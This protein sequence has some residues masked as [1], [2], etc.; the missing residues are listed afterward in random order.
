M[1]KVF[2][3]PIK[4]KNLVKRCN[5]HASQ[6]VKSLKDK[7]TYDYIIVGAGSAGSVLAHRLSADPMNKVLLLE[8][9]QDDKYFP[10]HVP[11][12][13]L[14]CIA[15]PRTDWLFKTTK[16]STLN[17]R[18][19][20]YPRGKCLGGCSSINGML[21]VRGQSEDYDEWARL[22]DDENWSW[23]NMLPLYKSHEDYHGLNKND[24]SR[25]FNNNFEYMN[26]DE[27]Y[28]RKYHGV[29]GPWAVS[30]PR[31][32][33]PV[34]DI[35]R[36][37]SME[38]G[39]EPTADFNTGNNYGIGFFDVS[40]KGGWRLTA[41]QAFVHQH[42][43]ISSPFYRPNLTVIP[44]TQVNKLIFDNDDNIS[45]CVGVHTL[46][47]DNNTAASNGDIGK[48][49][50]YSA[51]KEVILS[52]G[53]VGSV[54][55]LERSGIG[56][57]ERIGKYGNVISDLPGVGENL[58]DHLQ[59][60]PVFGVSNVPEGTMN[61]QMQS[62][63]GKIKIASQFMINQEGPLTTAPSFLGAFV[64][65][66]DE[67]TR[68]N[69][70]F[71][72]QPLSL[73]SFGSKFQNDGSLFAQLRDVMDKFLVSPLD[74][75]DAITASVVNIRPSSR[76]TV[77]ITGPNITDEPEINPNYLSTKEDQKVAIDSLKLMRKIVT[78]TKAFKSFN[79]VE[80][81][82]TV[83]LQSDEELLSAAR[84]LGTTIFHPV[85]TL[86]MGQIND[87]MTVVDNKLRVKGVKSL[88]IVDASIM[89]N[90]TSGN[91]AAPTMGIAERAAKYILED[92]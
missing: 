84:D 5:N 52:S 60:R 87:P 16:Q 29:G 25:P 91:T 13:Y 71:H 59:I 1:H 11:V 30:T 27:N 65:S 83:D 45:K 3:N 86:K 82:P 92:L 33:S 9:G 56:N 18:Q 39:I 35:F 57:G 51:R 40:Q 78:T 34:M 69:I 7:Y 2:I 67:Y 49:S 50:Y 72:I 75:Y 79:P 48:E 76:G 61:S 54:Q 81:R 26:Q 19:L 66:S 62:L 4:I 73:S 55:I 89:P 42:T 24:D 77:H 70:E 6:I 10:I 58:Q 15:N 64:K 17:G 28:M 63:S 38:C 44:K 31:L 32:Y 90:I 23:E 68:P 21:Y 36:D 37:A 43:Q 22:T 14:H 88:R 8:A 46:T 41:Y 74:E 12:G 85:G 47:F 53:S 20:I 80:I